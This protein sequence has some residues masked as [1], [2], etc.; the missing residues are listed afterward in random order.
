MPPVAGEKRVPRN[1]H[2]V[3][4]REIEGRAG[5]KFTY[6]DIV[7]ATGLPAGVVC[8]YLSLYYKKGYFHREK[9]Q[10]KNTRPLIDGNRGN[11]PF[12]W[13]TPRSCV[14]SFYW[15]RKPLP[16]MARVGDVVDGVW[17]VLQDASRVGAFISGKEIWEITCECKRKSIINAMSRLYRLG[18][19]DRQSSK[20]RLKK[21]FEGEKRPTM[22]SIPKYEILPSVRYANVA[23]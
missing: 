5:K 3:I 6:R 16:K 21:W 12:R 22:V 14:R 19:L 9:K 23:S 4:S 13:K 11:F 18:Y 8:R 7:L 20:Y 15:Q 17:K 10:V 1:Y 2:A